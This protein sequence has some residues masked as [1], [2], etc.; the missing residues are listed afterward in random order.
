MIRYLYAVAL[1]VVSVAIPLRAVDRPHAGTESQNAVVWTNENLD[2]IFVLE[3][4][5]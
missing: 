4:M 5:P 1:V 2:P 3:N